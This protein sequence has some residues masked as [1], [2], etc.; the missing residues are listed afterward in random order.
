MSPKVWYVSAIVSPMFFTGSAFA[1]QCENLIALSKTVTSTVADK[2]AFDKHAANFCSEYKKSGS[3]ASATNAGA[4]YKFLSAS[5][6]QT[7]MSTDDV[8]SKVCS[9]NADES[10]STEA[11]KQYVETIATGAY[12]A[13]ETCVRFK[14][15]NDLRFDVDLASVLPAE[16]TIAIGYSQAIQGADTSELIYSGS[17]GVTCT[18]D[19]KP[20]EKAKL[21]APSSVAVK[22]TRPEQGTPGYVRIIRTNGVGGS[23]TVP[24]PA[25]DKNG[26]PVA[27]LEGLKAQLSVAQTSLTQMQKQIAALAGSSSSP[28]IYICPIGKSPGV[29]PGGGA[30]G[31]Y[32]CQG[33]VTTQGTCINIEYPW[34]ETRPCAAHGELKFY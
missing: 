25:F 28:T 2:S 9:T 19:G 16:F 22:C 29:N 1:D 3:S 14:E 27:T 20:S 6:G 12:P 32:G 33:Q 13:Y 31:Y 15:N 26:I 17:S 21:R 4:S 5:F 10:A 24:W 23:L 7:A 18:W 30:W 34:N 11:Y 8:A